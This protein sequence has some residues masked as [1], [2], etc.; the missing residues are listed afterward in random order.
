MKFW[1]FEYPGPVQFAQCISTN[2]L[3][4]KNTVFPGL[5][6]TFEH[7]LREM[8]VGD[9]VLLA[10]LVGDEGKFLA[11]GRVRSK[12]DQEALPQIQWAATTF[13]RF[14]NASGGLINWQTKTAFEISPEPTKRYG[15]RKLLDHYVKDDA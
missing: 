4:Q 14:P 12:N 5:K 13:T 3:P 9:G 2:S 10:T 15:L 7:P 11:I 6:D 8:K 1:K